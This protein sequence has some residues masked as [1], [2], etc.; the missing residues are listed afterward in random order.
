M[1]RDGII[2]LRR[3]PDH[4]PGRKIG[5][6][7]YNRRHSRW[8]QRCN[9]TPVAW[10]TGPVDGPANHSCVRP[11]L[12]PRKSGVSRFP[13]TVGRSVAPMNFPRTTILIPIFSTVTLL[14]NSRTRANSRGRSSTWSA[15]PVTC[16][17]IPAWVKTAVDRW[18]YSAPVGNG[19][20]F[21]SIRKNGTVWGNGITQ[22]VVW[23]VVK[24]VRHV[25]ESPR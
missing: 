25:P 14:V 5:R 15:K 10:N 18:T 22:N 23:Y 2:R 6:E 7:S 21:R 3:E 12:A 9:R 17:P 8:H 16:V 1:N 13:N 11:V 24:A 19:R 20:L 4:Q